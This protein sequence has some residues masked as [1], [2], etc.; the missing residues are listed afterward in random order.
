M[1]YNVMK[2]YLVFEFKWN[3]K[4]EIEFIVENWF[5]F[6][7]C[8]EEVYSS[9][10]WVWGLYVYFFVFVCF[11]IGLYVGYFVIV[12]IYDGLK[13]KYLSVN[14]NILVVFFGFIRV[15]VLYLDLYY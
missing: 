13:G 12:N 1:Y 15:F 6:G 4:G 9:W 2:F 5:E 14:F 8:W 7:F 10:K 3:G 11:C